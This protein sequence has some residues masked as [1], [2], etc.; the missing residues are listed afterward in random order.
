MTGAAAPRGGWS[1]H[2]SRV[3]YPIG[4]ARAND[5]AASMTSPDVHTFYRRGQEGHEKAAGSWGRGWGKVGGVRLIF[6]GLAVVLLGGFVWGSLGPWLWPTLGVLAFAF[7]A[8]V[9]VHAQTEKTKERELAAARFY[10]RGLSRVSLAWGELPIDSERPDASAHVFAADLD[11]FG[12]GLLMQL[13]DATETG[14]AQKRLATL[15]SLAGPRPWPA[16]PAA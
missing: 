8:L 12:R 6:A 3:R 16:E 5:P 15:L 9:V 4:R 2:P 7:A 11:I 14:L 13:V 1:R 10:K